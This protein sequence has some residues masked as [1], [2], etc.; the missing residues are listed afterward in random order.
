VIQTRS[1]NR[2]YADQVSMQAAQMLV[3][4][5]SENDAEARDEMIDFARRMSTHARWL[6]RPRSMS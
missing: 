3:L 5:L 1:E 6:M 2:L 4:A